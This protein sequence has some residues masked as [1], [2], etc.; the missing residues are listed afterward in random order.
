MVLDTIP[1]KEITTT[2]SAQK[3]YTLPSGKT[4]YLRTLSI[5][6]L[7]TAN[8]TVEIWSGSG[9][10]GEDYRIMT[11]VVSAGSTLVL[12]KG[13]LE[14]RKAIKDIYVV[15]DQQPIRVSGSVELR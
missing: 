14:G 12:G 13:D 1:E 7:A 2:G 10:S 5:T 4:A 11:L 3:I 8:A 15:T 9:A 6:N